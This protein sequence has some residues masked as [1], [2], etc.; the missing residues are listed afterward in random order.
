MSFVFTEGLAIFPSP[1]MSQE[2]HFSQSINLKKKKKRS[3]S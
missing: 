3:D 2:E 1:I